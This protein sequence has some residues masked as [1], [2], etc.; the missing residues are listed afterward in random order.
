[1]ITFIII[2]FTWVFF[3]A[4]T[5]P[6]AAGYIGSMFGLTPVIENSFLINNIIYNPYYIITLIAAVVITWFGMQTWDWTKKISW[7]K[8]VI[9]AGLFILSIIILT[10]QAFNP[11]IY[12]IF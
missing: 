9:I 5:L 1:M 12:F 4:E 7:K 10:T 2:L 6:R 11:F 8:A 3:R